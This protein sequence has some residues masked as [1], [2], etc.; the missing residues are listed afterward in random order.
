MSEINRLVYEVAAKDAVWP[1]LPIVMANLDSGEIVFVSKPAADLFNYEVDDLLGK[2]LEVLVPPNVA[3]THENWRKDA[4]VPKIRTM[5]SGRQVYGRRKDGNLF[6]AHV[7]LME[8]PAIGKRIGVAIVVDLTVVID[9]VKQAA[10]NN[11]PTPRTLQRQD[12][13]TKTIR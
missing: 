5:G 4:S 7:S 13:A 9:V 2:P 6:P 8:A 12:D 11:D 10:K 1:L 3:T